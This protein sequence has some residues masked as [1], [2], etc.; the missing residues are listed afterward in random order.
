MIVDKSVF[1]WDGY[2][3]QPATLDRGVKRRL[4][5]RSIGSVLR[6]LASVFFLPRPVLGAIV[7][8]ETPRPHANDDAIGLC[9]NL[10]RPFEDK[11]V[12]AGAELAEIVGTLDLSRIAVRIPLSDIDNLQ[13]YVD[14]IR[15][16]PGYR[17]LGVIL[18]DRRTI[19]DP[20]RLESSLE[21]IF[22]ALSGTVDCF[23]IGNAV[24]RLKWGF[25]SVD[26]WLKFFRVAWDL[27]N[28]KFPHLRLLGGAIIDFDLLDHCRSLRNGLPFGYDGYA[29][30][31]YVDRRGAPEN[32]QMGFDLEGKIHVLRRIMDSGGKVCGTGAR[33]WITEVNWPLSD[34]GRYAPAMDH[35]QVGERE[36]LHYLVRYYLLALATGSVAA[37][38]WH[39]LVA[40]G[41]G[42]ID[43][44]GGAVRKRP[45]FRGFATLCRLFNGARIERFSRQDELGYYRLVARKDGMEILALWCCGREATV[46]MPADK[47]ALDIVG[48]EITV[49][50]G[51]PITI[52]ESVVY[53]VADRPDAEQGPDSMAQELP[54][55]LDRIE[56]IAPN[57][58]RRLSG[59][60]ATVARLLPVQARTI[61][62]VATGPG[63]PAH[64]PRVPLGS[65]LAMSRRKRRVWHARRNTEMLLG[66]VLRH[67]LRKRLK[68]VFT[69]ASQRR[70]TRY[71][72]WLV[73]R[74]DA[75]VSTS[76]RTASYL[77]RPSRV[78]LH[79]IDAAAFHPPA[80]R[81]ALRRQLGLPEALTV[82]CFGRI[83][84]QKGTDVFVDTMLEV[85]R[86]HPRVQALVM[87]R[88]TAGHQPFLQSLSDRVARAGLRDRIR[89][90]PEAAVD[91][92]P[93]WYQALDLFVAP[94]RWEGFGVTPL[95]AMA[96]GVP[97]VATTAGA[98]D[99]LV[100]DGVTGRLVPPGDVRRMCAAVDEALASPDT[101]REW[102]T[103]ARR[104]IEEGFRIEDEA[105]ALNG[106]YRE[107]LEEE[108]EGR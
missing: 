5:W 83:R 67:V 56:V 104:R 18:Q 14:F 28:R 80:D 27:R 74:M 59:V 6:N 70:H 89:F 69:S 103:A 97:V 76:Q 75:V 2:S 45:A 9:V 33:L 38:Y 91:A 105:A 77:R 93:R 78:I 25:V 1:R 54:L 52:G 71:T 44:R 84:H 12:L 63:L 43:N 8:R 17:I 106:L 23:Q 24:N 101:L 31:L 35:C 34:T 4:R 102:S 82:G 86:R 42:L 100:V 15:R 107:L 92:M 20:G 11:K 26:E 47:R 58:K 40:P 98:F 36:Q 64:V 73:A 39:Q 32:R 49:T 29:S 46:A 68:L 51:E 62:I 10:E 95:E 90:L 50:Q 72:R 94:Q 37:C 79:G 85:L 7:G 88:A 99:E 81:S 48:A 66:L 13:E 3:D 60:T 55:T 19:E 96:C 53:L 65:V 21:K 16:F 87:G 41:Y 30:L 108:G 57:L 22:D 61:G